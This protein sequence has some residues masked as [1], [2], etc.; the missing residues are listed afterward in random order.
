MAWLRVEI[1][2]L[3]LVVLCAVSIIIFTLRT[4][5]SPMPTSA[6]MRRAAFTL[7]PEDVP[8][9]IYELGA[10]W[11]TLLA[12]LSRRYPKHQLVGFEVSPLPWLVAKVRL[13]L[14]GQE[15]AKVLRKDFHSADLSDAGLVV[16][17]LFPAGMARL[18]S[19]L[20]EQLAPGSWVLSNT[21]AIPGWTAVATAKAKDVYRSPIYLYRVP[22]GQRVGD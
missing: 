19:H 16:C 3:V 15:R 8:G 11:G 4:G 7:L 12:P 2:V 21:F 18:K 22:E 10:G 6:A 1:A 13:K 9:V 17:Y 20:Q 5:I 14:M